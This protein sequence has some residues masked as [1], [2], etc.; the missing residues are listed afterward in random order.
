MRRRDF[1]ALVGAAAA[2]W[3]FAAAAQSRLLSDG[4]L[5]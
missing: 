4:F 3:P 5:T 2:A 1:I